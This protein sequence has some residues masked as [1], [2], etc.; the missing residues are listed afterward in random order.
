MLSTFKLRRRLSKL[1][2]SQYHQAQA[3]F[4]HRGFGI[5][6]VVG[7]F[8]VQVFGRVRQRATAHGTVVVGTTRQDVVGTI[9]AGIGAKASSKRTSKAR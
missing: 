5:G 8:G 4:G 1:K 2:L 6:L 7:T 3:I 9:V